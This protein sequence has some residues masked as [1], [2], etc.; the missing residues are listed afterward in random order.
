MEEEKVTATKSRRF[1]ALQRGA[2]GV[3]FGSVNA[4]IRTIALPLSPSTYANADSCVAR[5]KPGGASVP[6]PAILGPD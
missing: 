3:P 6:G 5:T 2:H 1:G 4:R